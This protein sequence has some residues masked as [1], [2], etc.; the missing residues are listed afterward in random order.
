M[1]SETAG[2]YSGIFLRL[3]LRIGVYT[4]ILKTTTTPHTNTHTH[5]PKKNTMKRSRHSISTFYKM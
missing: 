4:F 3:P 5:T 1:P 2:V